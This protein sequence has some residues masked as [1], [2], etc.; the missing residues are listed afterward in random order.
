MFRL[1]NGVIIPSKEDLLEIYGALRQF[2]EEH[3][4]EN[5]IHYGLRYDGILTM[6]VSRLQ[7]K[8][9]NKIP[10]ENALS[11]SEEIF[12]RILCEHPFND[13]NKRTALIASL[14]FLFYNLEAYVNKS[15]EKKYAL[16]E[17]PKSVEQQLNYAKQ[18]EL[19]ASWHDETTHENLYSFL[20]NNGIKIRSK[21]SISEGHIRQ[22]LRKFLMLWVVEI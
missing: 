10:L 1:K 15:S 21:N 4:K 13:G 20:I 19:L 22:Y 7:N 16:S 8:N 2:T 12:F 5:V 14:D 6:L 18:L 17:K 3:L 11:V 9:Y